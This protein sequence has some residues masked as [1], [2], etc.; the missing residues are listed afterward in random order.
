ML[1]WIP[2]VHLGA[3]VVRYLSEVYINFWL[4]RDGD[5]NI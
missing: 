5:L 3:Q 2:I 4:D 1:S